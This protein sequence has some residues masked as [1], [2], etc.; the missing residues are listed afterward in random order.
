MYIQYSAGV[1]ELSWV[2]R[3]SRSHVQSPQYEPFWVSGTSVEIGCYNTAV[4]VSL[5][6]C[7]MDILS[8]L[9]GCIHILDTLV[10]INSDME[11]Q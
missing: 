8:L 11:I 5:I 10:L 1:P 7:G 6:D 4:S 2:S 9:D 3:L